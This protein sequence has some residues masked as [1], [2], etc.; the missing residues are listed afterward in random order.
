MPHLPAEWIA[1]LPAMPSLR[2]GSRDRGGNPRVCRALAAALQ[3]DGRMLVLLAERNA[4]LV[5]AAVRETGQ[6][7][8]LATSPRTYRTL[9]LKGHDAHVALACADHALLLTQQRA[10]L[11]QE[12]SEVDGFANAPFLHNWFDVALKDLV[13][14]HFSIAGAWN[15]TPGPQAGQVIELEPTP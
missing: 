2:L 13:A 6:V 3:H 14:V 4:P 7:A 8:L 15:Q 1:H 11:A 10:T 9:H 5:V 12:L